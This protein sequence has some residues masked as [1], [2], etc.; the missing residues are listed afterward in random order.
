MNPTEAR[1]PYLS[2]SGCRQGFRKNVEQG[3]VGGRGGYE[4]DVL[5]NPGHSAELWNGG[6]HCSPNIPSLGVSALGVTGGPEGLALP[7]AV[8]GLDLPQAG[9]W[10][11]RQRPGRR[12]PAFTPA[13]ISK[14]STLSFN[15]D[16]HP[17]SASPSD[18]VAGGAFFSLFISL[19][20]FFFICIF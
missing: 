16:V 4:L 10:F 20:E 19:R 7:G 1:T 5:K 15:S 14:R 2:S 18:T 6:C 12:T 13:C 11:Q 8:P 17:E 9:P 3:G